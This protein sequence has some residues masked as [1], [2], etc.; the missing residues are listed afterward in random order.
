MKHA[1]ERGEDD[2]TE[3]R[4]SFIARCRH[5]DLVRAAAA[6]R[7]GAGPRPLGAGALLPLQVAV[8]PALLEPV[9]QFVEHSSLP[10]IQ[11]RALAPS[12]APN[13]G[14]RNSAFPNRHFLVREVKR[15]A[16]K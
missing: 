4:A 12:T 11:V 8:R 14:S 16:A 5:W 10:R 15:H 6:A 1:E 3:L 13:N 2:E 7:R 9:R